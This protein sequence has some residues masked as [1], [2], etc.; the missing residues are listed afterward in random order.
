MQIFN[1]EIEMGEGSWYS[2]QGPMQ[3][4]S[5]WNSKSGKRSI[6]VI[7]SYLNDNALDAKF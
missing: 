7:G 5:A 1:K 2:L 6:F 4:N 3:G